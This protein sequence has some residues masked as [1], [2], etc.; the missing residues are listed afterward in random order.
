MARSQYVKL[1]LA[2]M[3]VF[4]LFAGGFGQKA[5]AAASTVTVK[6]L[7]EKGAVSSEKQAEIGETETAFDALVKTVGTDAVNYEQYSFGK[8]ITEISGLAAKDNIYWGF[9]INGISAMTGADSYKPQNGDVLTFRYESEP[10]AG[11]VNLVIAGKD[12]Q[13][14]EYKDISFIDKPNAFQLLQTVVGPENLAYVQYDFGKMISS[15]NG[16]DT[17]TNSFWSFYVND[18]A[19]M[20]GAESYTLESE[21]TI[22]FKY[23]TF[24]PP[25]AEEPGKGEPGKDFAVYPADSFSKDLNETIAYVLKNKQLG[26]WEAIALKQAGK[27]IP[28]G[29][30]EGV[31]K[32]VKDRSGKFR[33]IT[34]YERYTLGILAAGGNPENFAG[35]NLVEGIYNGDFSKQGLNGAAYGLIALDSADFTIPADAKWTKENLK[36]HLITNQ[37]SDGGWGL[38]KE[39]GSDPDTTS[40]VLTALAPYKDEAAVKPV[41]DKGIQYLKNL[42]ASS[43]VDSSPAAAQ[44]V[45]ALSA[46]GLDANSGIITTDGKTLLGYLASFKHSGGGF[47][48]KAG[49]GADAISTGQGFQALVAYQLFKDGKG[50]LYKLTIDQSAGPNSVPGNEDPGNSKNEEGKEEGHRLPDTATNVYSLLAFGMV[51]VA[52]GGI[53]LMTTRRKRL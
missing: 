7:G 42:F 31:A 19:Q 48:W 9:Y 29:Y 36:A 46:L 47:A 38:D 40:M 8:M 2:L 43:K 26:E 39:T 1:M 52:A 23:E 34:D 17:T 10:P 27:P 6:V 4:T 11:K 28:A 35:Y 53:L 50:S 30:L 51:L 37:N 15:I 21:K 5:A 13:L 41:I 25:P 45:I 20:V 44:A 12:N 18:E 32:R 3:L 22:A 16:L 14:K 24:T 33:T 49:D